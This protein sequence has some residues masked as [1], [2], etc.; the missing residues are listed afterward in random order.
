MTSKKLRE[1]ERALAADPHNPVVR[2]K[3]AAA[4]RDTGRLPD[5]VD[6]YRAVAVSYQ[7]EGRLVQALAVC[8]AILEIAPDDFPTR[9]LHEEIEAM[10]TGAPGEEPTR[11]AGDASRDAALRPAPAP[12][13]MVV[14]EVGPEDFEE[15]EDTMKTGER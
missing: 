4:L 12:A 11:L 9:V 2:L 1:A 3:L 10:R 6:I 5:A 8:R 7:Q 15:D 13:P 14:E